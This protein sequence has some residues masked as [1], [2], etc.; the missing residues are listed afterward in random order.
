MNKNKK[1]T[2]INKL[3]IFCI[4]LTI[5]FL[6]WRLWLYTFYNPGE[7]SILRTLT[8]LNIHHY[9]Y[10]ITLVLIATLLFIFYKV[11]NYSIV[12]AGIGFG[13]YFDGFISRL[14]KSS[15]RATEIFNYNNNLIPTTILF[16]TLII[17]ISIFYLITERYKN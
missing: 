12:I 3:I 17:I 2:Q 8:G 7:T 9:H 10:G 4:S 11:N 13:T 15:T 6:F 14:F 1:P 16:T 5:P